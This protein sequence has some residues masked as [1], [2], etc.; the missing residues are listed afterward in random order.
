MRSYDSF[1]KGAEEALR[2][3]GSVAGDLFRGG[4][5]RDLR[6]DRT[7]WSGQDH[8]VSDPDHA[9]VG[10]W[11]NSNRGWLGCRDAIQGDSPTDRLHAR[12]F[13]ALSRPIGRGEP[14]V[15]RDHLRH[16]HSSEL[17]FGGRHLSADRALQGSQ[18]G[19]ALGG[20]ETE[21]GPVMRLDPC[22]TGAVP[23]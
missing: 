8:A 13:L 22:A 2:Q 4:R 18:G 6:V 20:Y 19:Q 16:D 10:R 14:P 7:G 5:G 23:R 11:R 21:V 9:A 12:S 15:F 1:G 3:G 17:R